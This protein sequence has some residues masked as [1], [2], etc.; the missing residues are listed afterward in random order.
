VDCLSPIALVMRK[1]KKSRA[2]GKKSNAQPLKHVEV[3]LT[4]LEIELALR[5][6]D[7]DLTLGIRRAIIFASMRQ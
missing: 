6:G 5:V 2:G 3:E 1:K 4:A 7:G